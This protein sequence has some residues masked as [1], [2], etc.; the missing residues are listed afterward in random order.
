M[1]GTPRTLGPNV[2]RYFPSCLTPR[3]EVA[4]SHDYG[5]ER[6]AH[7]PVRAV[8]NRTGP[9]AR[10]RPVASRTIKKISHYRSPGFARVRAHPTRNTPP[11]RGCVPALSREGGEE[12]VFA[13]DVLQRKQL[14]Q[15]YVLYFG[16]AN[17]ISRRS[18]RLPSSSRAT[19]RISPLSVLM[20]NASV[21]SVLLAAGTV[22]FWTASALCVIPC[23]D[24]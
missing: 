12:S 24:S 16:W 1:S 13:R 14:S 5:I 11:L 8:R 21:T 9:R 19:R 10:L 23:I 4:P 6:R 7:F 22:V 18:S 2:L 17:W 20:F 15:F 3:A